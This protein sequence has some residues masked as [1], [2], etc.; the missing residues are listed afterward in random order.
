LLLSTQPP[1]SLPDEK[2]LAWSARVWS[3]LSQRECEGLLWIALRYERTRSTEETVTYVDH[4]AQ[5]PWRELG[6]ALQCDL[7][8]T[9]AKLLKQLQT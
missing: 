1:P 6:Y 4:M 9:F 8:G 5:L 2:T 7:A 3:Q